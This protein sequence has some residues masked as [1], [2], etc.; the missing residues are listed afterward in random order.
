MVEDVNALRP[1]CVRYHAAVELI[2][3]RWSGAILGTLFTAHR[4]YA[5]IRT[6]I[7]GVSD[8]M[9]AQRLRELETAG[10]IERQVL[11]TSPVRVEYQLTQQGRELRPVVDAL[12]AW[13]HKW[14]PLPVDGPADSHTEDAA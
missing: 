1:V 8:T 13:S 6:S 3:A 11:A 5:D 2:G 9:L 7:P 12:V 14:I 10:L 4:R